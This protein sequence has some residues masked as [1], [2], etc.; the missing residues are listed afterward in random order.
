MNIMDYLAWRGDLSFAADPFAE[1]DD[2]VLSQLSYLDLSG[3]VPGGFTE[4]IGL[5]EAQRAYAERH[6]DIEKEDV[7][8]LVKEC[9]G[10]FE[11]MAKSERYASALL[12]G[13]R[14]EVSI[15]REYQFAAVTARLS[16]G[17]RYVSFSGTDSTVAGWKEDFNL[18]FMD[19]TPG[20]EMALA[21]LT[22]A[23]GSA[24]GGVICGGHS[25]GG[26][27]AVYAAMHLRPELQDRLIA[28]YN[29]DGP[30][31]TQKMMNG[32]GYAAIQD[33]LRTFLPRSSVVGLLMDHT[34]DYQVVRSSGRGILQH[35]VFTWEVLGKHPVYAEALSP[36]SAALDQAFKTWLGGMDDETRRRFV[37]SLFSILTKGNIE[38]TGAL[39]HMSPQQLMDLIRVVGEMD[40]EGK[41]AVTD[42]M[43][44]LLRSYGEAEIDRRGLRGAADRLERLRE[45]IKKKKQTLPALRA[46]QPEKKTE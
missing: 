41:E 23:I 12:S 45:N 44:S 1:A 18:A 20:Q 38:D 16:T 26:N 7:P 8:A 24:P 25:K 29:N 46:D 17:E 21:Y 42:S 36:E 31:F 40:A 5:A 22:E 33:R 3:I 19:K 35:D 9:A 39:G 13:C 11:A 27:F 14:R 34:S 15:E 28:V 37:D 2:L 10:L 6:P 43:R 30:G 32:D 4:E